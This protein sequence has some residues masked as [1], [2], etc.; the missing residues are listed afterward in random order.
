MPIV[1][2]QEL[3]SLGKMF[4]DMVTQVVYLKDYDWLIKVF[5]E[6]SYKDAD[7]ILRE[8]DD[9]DCEPEF[10]YSAAEILDSDKLNTGF[11][12]TN[13]NMRVTFLVMTETSCADE[14]QNT[15]DHEKGHAA[16]H[17]GAEL[18]FDPEGEQIQYL[19]GEI[20]R[21]MFKVA[22]QFMCDHCRASIVNYGKIKVKFYQR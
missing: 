14:F 7:I 16:Q 10:Y 15:F 19:Q 8:L 18:G 20:G 12:Y 21:E 22:K 9:I 1:L 2:G 4:C 5:Y 6:V 13:S 17:I 3:A 11:T